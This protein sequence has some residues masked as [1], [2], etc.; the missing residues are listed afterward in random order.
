M[1]T[2]ENKLPRYIENTL[3]V[4]KDKYEIRVFIQDAFNPSVQYVSSGGCMT[5]RYCERGRPEVSFSTDCHALMEAIGNRKLFAEDECDSCNQIFGD[6]I[7]TQFGNWSLPYRVISCIRGKNGY[8]SIKG[9]GWRIDSSPEGPIIK[10][11]EA[12]DFADIDQVIKSLKFRRLPRTSFVPIAV[13][14]AL[15]RMAIALMPRDE[16]TEF[17]PVIDWLLEKDSNIRPETLCSKVLH[18]VIPAFPE[19]DTVCAVLARRHTDELDLPYMVF[20]L[21]FSN[22]AFQV[23]VPSPQTRQN[24]SFT[25]T[26]FPFLFGPSSSQPLIPEIL[27]LG[28][29]EIVRNEFVPLG[30]DF[31]SMTESVTS[32]HEYIAT[33]AYFIWQARGSRHGNDV[34]DWLEAEKQVTSELFDFNRKV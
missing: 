15:V 34:V 5:C 7:E 2:E 9:P 12:H 20:V 16:L 14:K 26:I 10:T 21:L 28:G 24:E 27:D 8:P 33:R 17:K 1:N 4:Y 22:Y 11:D 23:F 18:V 25:A 31:Q 29:I 32:K 3:G 19:P 6:G 13:Y 30:I